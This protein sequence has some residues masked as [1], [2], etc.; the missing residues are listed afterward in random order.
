[1]SEQEQNTERV[2]ASISPELKAFLRE[3]VA[4]GEFASEADVVR[5]ALARLR[6]QPGGQPAGPDSARGGER[7]AG[8]VSL[9]IY[10][11]ALIGSQLLS[12][13]TGKQVKPTSFIVSAIVDMARPEKQGR[14]R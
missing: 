8:L 9:M 12:V 10:T 2:G 1:M 11:N 13:L 7:L 4:S 14:N 6:D 5:E 3:A